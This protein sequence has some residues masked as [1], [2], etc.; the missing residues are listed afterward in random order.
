MLHHR[1]PLLLTL[2][3]ALQAL[4]AAARTAQDYFS[5]VGDAMGVLQRWYDYDTGLWNTTGW[6]NSA[7]LVTMLADATI[8][9]STFDNTTS[10]IFTNTF[11]KAQE[12]NLEENRIDMVRRCVAPNCPGNAPVVVRPRGFINGFFDDEGWWALAWIRV[13][14]LTGQQQWLDAASFIFNDMLSTG[15]NAT[16]GGIWWDRDHTQNAAIANEL[17]L[18]VAAHLANRKPNGDFYRGWAVR[19]WDWFRNSGLINGAGNINDGL[20]LDTC[21]NNNGTVWTYNQGVILGGLVELAA[22]T[23][24]DSHITTAT[25]IASAAIDT[26]ADDNGII[27]DKYEDH[28]DWEDGHTFKGV[29]VR[30]LAAL[31]AATG[32][33]GFSDFLTANADSVWDVAR[34][35]GTGEIGPVWSL[36]G[37]VKSAGTQGSGLDALVAAGAVSSG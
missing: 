10:E 15:Y 30:N 34:D 28:A 6:W 26:L 1:G 17:F 8:A 24:D 35:R 3:T 37:G 2:C 19:Q 12:T 25:S 4:P 27:H 22:A 29:F 20:N 14:D 5:Q 21:R 11:E 31:H 18:S 13:Y 23:G 7:N 36:G 32:D 16:C 33:A 9:D